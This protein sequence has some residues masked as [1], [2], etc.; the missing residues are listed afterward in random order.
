MISVNLC[1]QQ[2]KLYENKKK[3]PSCLS[4]F[5]SVVVYEL[6]VIS[7][8]LGVCTAHIVH[9]NIAVMIKR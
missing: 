9:W 5:L 6:T 8:H 1:E 2:K 4:C 7:R 3:F